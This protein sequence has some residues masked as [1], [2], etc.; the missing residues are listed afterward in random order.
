ML[1]P[2]AGL[3]SSFKPRP[4]PKRGAE[5]PT[6]PLPVE[7]YGRRFTITRNN[8]VEWLGWSLYV[9]A[10]PTS[11]SRLWDVRF[12]GQRIAYEISLQEA[13][14]GEWLRPVT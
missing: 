4:G 1:S 6:G 13:L 8:K 9:G 12:K 10:M 14:A 2:S 11:G 5:A 3:F 7:P